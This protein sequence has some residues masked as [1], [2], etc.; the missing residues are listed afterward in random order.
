PQDTQPVFADVAGSP[1]H[2]PLPGPRADSPQQANSVGPQ[3][4]FREEVLLG[5]HSRGG[6][7][8]HSFLAARGCRLERF[9]QRNSSRSSERRPSPLWNA[10]DYE[11]LFLG[12]EQ[13]PGMPRTA[14]SPRWG[15]AHWTGKDRG[16]RSRGTCRYEVITR[17]QTLAFEFVDVK[18]KYG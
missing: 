11:S 16:N 4:S 2:E 13:T 17:R 10:E 3:K 7:R 9:P 15:Q 6:V 12:Q 18:S 14:P 5:E 1:T 8:Y